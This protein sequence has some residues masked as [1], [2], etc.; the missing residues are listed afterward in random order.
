MGR[1]DHDHIGPEVHRRERDFGA[2]NLSG[3]LVSV[4]AAMIHQRAAAEADQK[5]ANT[6]DQRMREARDDARD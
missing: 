1:Q 3:V 5:I 6:L 4:R 2:R